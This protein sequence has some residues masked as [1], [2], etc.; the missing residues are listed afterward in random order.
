MARTEAILLNDEIITVEELNGIANNSVIYKDNSWV[1]RAVALWDSW[2]LLQSNWATSAPSFDVNLNTIAP[3]ASPTFTWLVTTPAIKITTWAGDW[4]VAT[5]DADW[6]LTWETPTWW[7][8]WAIELQDTQWQNYSWQ[9]I[10]IFNATTSWTLTEVTLIS[11]AIPVGADATLELRKNSYTSGSVLS[12][13]LTIATTDTL[14]NWK[15]QVST[16]SFTSATITDG[17]Y[18]VAYLVTSWTTSP[19]M[20][21]KCVIRYS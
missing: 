15:K 18:F 4:K 9:I 21:A 19:L 5:S 16:T 14:T 1:Y 20:N 12:S 3:L 11:D 17:D 7:W 13:V 6:N 8:G 10:G 2:E